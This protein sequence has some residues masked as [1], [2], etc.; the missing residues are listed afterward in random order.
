[1]VKVHHG[2]AAVT[3]F[4]PFYFKGKSFS[5]Q[6]ATVLNN[7]EWEGTKKTRE[8]RRPVCMNKTHCPFRGKWREVVINGIH[9]LR[10]I[11]I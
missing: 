3:L 4:V 6:K 7:L 10:S 9:P 11:M 1:M 2:P 8:V 5:K